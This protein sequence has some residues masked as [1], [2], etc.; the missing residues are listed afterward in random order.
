M[1]AVIPGRAPG[2]VAAKV[3]IDQVVQGPPMIASMFVLM[4]LLAG[5]TLRDGVATC[6]SRL[7]DVWVRSVY[8]WAPF[9]AFQQL[10]VP[11]HYRV[12][13]A[14]CLSYFWDTYMAFEMSEE[15]DVDECHVDLVYAP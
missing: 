12:V 13:A 2:A 14:N 3:V 4:G 10:F 7:R 9:Q 8:V 11:L 15:C 1:D 5:G 6:R